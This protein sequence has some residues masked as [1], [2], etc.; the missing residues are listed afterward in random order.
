MALKLYTAPVTL[1]VTVA[2]AKAQCRVDI[3]DDDTLIEAMIKAASDRCEQYTGRVVMHQHWEL[4]LDEFPDA[5]ELTRPPV[6]A[7]SFVK[8]IDS[9]GIEQT[10]SSGDYYLDKASD[11]GS[12]YI[13]PAYGGSW[14]TPRTQANA[15]TVRFTCGHSSAS[16]VP[17]A[18]K[19]WIL[20]MVAAMYE[21][22]E[23][24]TEKE[25]KLGFADTL[26]DRYKVY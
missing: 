7:V 18:I 13:V 15:V 21:Y 3:S 9:A 2:E 6:T 1:P 22:R 16:D 8:Y 24:Y 4:A 25:L 19:Q 17:P 5:I 20:L 11:F 23:A 26:L 12:A 10:M 14:P